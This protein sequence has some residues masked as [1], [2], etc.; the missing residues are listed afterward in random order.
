[1]YVRTIIVCL[2]VCP[3]VQAL[4]KRSVSWN[5][6][7]TTE[8]SYPRYTYEDYDEYNPEGVS[9]DAVPDDEDTDGGQ[10]EETTP[11]TPIHPSLQKGSTAPIKGGVTISS[12]TPSI[13]ASLSSFPAYS[14]PWSSCNTRYGGQ[15]DTST[16]TSKEK[17][18]PP[19][20]PPE[21]IMPAEDDAMGG[22]GEP[23]QGALLW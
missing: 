10:L 8:H 15:E 9:G 5:D 19:S 18:E 2:S 16:A 12:Y 22:W 14:D 20:P 3:L 23:N 4:G 1:M 21:E 6:L 13:L 17:E 11:S 7:Q